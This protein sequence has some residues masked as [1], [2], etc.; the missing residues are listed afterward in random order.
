M[1]ISFAKRIIREE[2]Q[3][4]TVSA[5]P[6]K[7]KELKFIEPINATFV[8]FESFSNDYDAR[9]SMAKIAIHWSPVFWKNPMGIHVFK[10]DIEGVEGMYVLELRDKQSDELMQ[11]T[12][13]NIAEIP[14]KFNVVEANLQLGGSLYVMEAEFDFKNNICTVTF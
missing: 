14:W 4:A 6:I 12:P 2:V 8:N 3:N 5:T 7:V 11:Q 13:K 10:I 9:V 1:D